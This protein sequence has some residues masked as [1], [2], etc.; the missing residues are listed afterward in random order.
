MKYQKAVN[1]MIQAKKFLFF[2]A[3]LFSTLLHDFAFSFEGSSADGMGG[4]G[5]A[6]VLMDNPVL[7][8][9]ASQVHLR[10]YFMNFH[11]QV[12]NNIYFE[13]ENHV[14]Q[15]GIIVT[16]NSPENLFATSLSAF[17][18][19]QSLENIEIKSRHYQ[20][21]LADF[22]VPTLA[23]GVALYYR[24]VEN[25]EEKEKFHQNNLKLG[26]LY[27]PLSWLGLAWTADNVLEEKK[28]SYK[29]RKFGMG[30]NYLA[31]IKLR[32]SLD[33]VKEEE[34]DHLLF[35]WGTENQIAPW[36][37]LRLGW[38]QDDNL[39]QQRATLGIGWIS[40]RIRLNYAFQ[41]DVKSSS[42]RKN[43]DKEHSLSSS[44]PF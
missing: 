34:K 16:D 11:H 1:S 43:Q 27:T 36:L 2:S 4:A 6:S 5:R 42:K 41:I 13:E 10:G 44:I 37:S 35:M 17:Q 18:E 26:L 29:K 7:L 28:Q 30:V 23:L 24:E 21:S 12:K 8:N 3:L 9:P 25:P 19:T 31:S 22:I 38:K 32:M 33:L 15:W 39:S 14:I 20:I 40:P